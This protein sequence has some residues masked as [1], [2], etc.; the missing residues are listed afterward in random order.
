[1][2]TRP[3]EDPLAASLPLRRRELLRAAI[4]HTLVDI[5]R[6]TATTPADFVARGGT[7]TQH[8][9]ECSGAT[10]MLFSEGLAHAMEGWPSQL[11]ITVDAEPFRDVS[12]SE[13][14]RLSAC[15]E[16]APAWLRDCLGRTVRDVRVYVF[17]DDVLS[18]EARQAAVSYLL[19]SGV[20]LFYCT[21][22]HG[23]GDGDE[24]LPGD[25]VGRDDVA[26]T[27][28]MAAGD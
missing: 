28:S 27:V 1:L 16:T 25:Q 8:F 11:S 19:D 9:S 22:L 7:A 17:R 13:R 5:E 4:G 10:V 2:T 14:Y 12:Y 20:E 15:T 18:D 3:D 23:R 21:Q 24:L 26:L 6:W